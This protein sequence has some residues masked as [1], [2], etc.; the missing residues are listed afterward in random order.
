MPDLIVIVMAYLFIQMCIVWMIYIRTNNPSIVDVA[1]PVGLFMSG[2]IYTLESQFTIFNSIVLTLLF[3]WSFRLGFYIWFTRIQKNIVDK[4]YLE[5]SSDWKIRKSLGY[6]LNYQLQAIFI[7]IISSVF[8]FSATASAV[9][10]DLMDGIATAIVITGIC[11]ESLADWQLHHFKLSSHKKVCN[12]G[13]WN[14]SRHPNYFFDWLTWCGFSLFALH[15]PYGY[16]AFASPLL[17][18]IIFTKITGPITERSSLRS[19]GQDFIEYQ[20]RTSF[21]FP[22]FKRKN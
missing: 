11:G 5:I 18:L 17:L 21:F 4:R 19:R 22:W 16:I 14:Y 20:S 7:L 12:V 1:W 6:F 15:H 9:T 10:F 8:Y 2:L 13:L 3:C